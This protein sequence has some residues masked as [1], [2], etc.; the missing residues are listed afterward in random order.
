LDFRL[1]TACYSISAN[2]VEMV[3]SEYT[4]IAVETALISSLLA[5]ITYCTSDLTLAILEFRLPI[6]SDNHLN[7]IVEMADPK[8]I[9]VAVGISFLAG[10][11]P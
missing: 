1:S 6:T 3:D 10:I 9:G 11:E 7:N 2:T 4:G 5:E 8:N